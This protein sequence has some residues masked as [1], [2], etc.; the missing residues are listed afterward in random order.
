MKTIN[1]LQQRTSD[2]THV[3]FKSGSWSAGDSAYDFSNPDFEFPVVEDSITY[4]M[5][6]VDYEY[7]KLVSGAIWATKR[8]KGD[9]DISFQ[10]ATNN[11]EVA[12]L[13]GMVTEVKNSTANVLK[14]PGSSTAVAAIMVDTSSIKSAKGTVIFTD[15]T[16]NAEILPNC[17]LTAARG[18]DSVAYWNVKVIPGNTVI[19]TA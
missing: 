4:S 2:F 19:M 11:K 17:E 12:E 9:P 14:T 13:F 8:S 3:Y 7:V 15:D 6:E 5:G 16:G 10:V 18:K 1:D